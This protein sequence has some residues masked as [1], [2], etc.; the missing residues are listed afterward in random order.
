MRYL[1]IVICCFILLFTVTDASGGIGVGA[2]TGYG[3]LKYTE[4]TDKLG[5]ERDSDAVLDALI[6]GG[7]IEYSFENLRGVYT[8]F[9]TDWVIGLR[10]SERWYS[11]SV[12]YQVNDLSI[13][14][15]FYDARIGYRGVLD[16]LHYTLYLSGGWDGIHFRRTRFLSDHTRKNDVITEDFSLWRT[17]GGMGAGYTLGRIGIE[18]RVAYGYYFDGEIRNSSHAGLV[19]DTNGTC[20]DLGA[21]ISYPIGERWRIY[22]GL[23]YTLI[24]LDESDLQR[25]D[26][27]VSIFPESRTVIVSGMFN[28]GYSF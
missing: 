20:L 6:L 4:S 17:G 19:Y 2:H 27:V 12:L 14:G 23:S 21:G 1:F 10:D 8:S 15:Q 26:S 25:D 13:F 28:V 3:R 11:N 18:A 22:G 16:R 7:S 24:S 5:D 9:V